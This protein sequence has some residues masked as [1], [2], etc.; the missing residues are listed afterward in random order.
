MD[1]KTYPKQNWKTKLVKSARLA[2]YRIGFAKRPNAD[3][4]QIEHRVLNS[5]PGPR[6]KRSGGSVSPFWTSV[7]RSVRDGRP[8]LAV[9]P[10]HGLRFGELCGVRRSALHRGLG[11]ARRA[12]TR[13]LWRVESA[14]QT[15]GAARQTGT[16]TAPRRGGGDRKPEG[17][18]NPGAPDRHLTGSNRY[19]AVY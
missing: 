19:A 12:R 13:R 2:D 11:A 4:P 10:I 5:A 14:L 8:S 17:G 1:A 15:A 9:C 7:P 6:K 16:R 3:R 18:L